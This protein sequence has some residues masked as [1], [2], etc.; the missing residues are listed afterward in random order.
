VPLNAAII[1]F[2]NAITGIIIWE[3]GQVIQSWIGYVCVFLLLALGCG[4]LLGDVGLLQETAP[5]TFR[6][7]RASM[8]IKSERTKML[9]NIK[10]SGNL[11]DSSVHLKLDEV[12]PGESA[13]NHCKPNLPTSTPSAAPRRSRASLFERQRTRQSKQAWA[14]IYAVGY[15]SSPGSRNSAAGSMSI[16]WS[17]LRRELERDIMMSS[18]LSSEDLLPVAPTT[19]AATLGLESV[20]ECRDEEYSNHFN[21]ESRMCAGKCEKECAKSAFN[22]NQWSK[23]EAR[24]RRRACV[25]RAV[26]DES[27][28]QQKSKD[29]KTAAARRK[30]EEAN[31]YDIDEVELA[32]LE[33]EGGSTED[34]AL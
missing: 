8:F 16:R 33:G 1:I 12:M 31:A 6:G 3:D 4:L 32:D 25:E 28:H 26:Q 7:A 24:S 13:E 34:L 23:G 9:D 5:E 29:D 30:E 17:S 2:I 27:T 18:E 21:E 15:E 22:R 11:H 10:N 19:T 20:Q 14:S